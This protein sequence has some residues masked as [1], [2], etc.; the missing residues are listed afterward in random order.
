MWGG[1][2][3]QGGAAFLW[4]DRK[5]NPQEK[6]L[7]LDKETRRV[8]KQIAGER[9]DMIGLL[10]S[11][12]NLRRKAGVH[13]PARPGPARAT[14]LDGGMFFPFAQLEG[15]GSDSGA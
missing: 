2:W 12:A 7:G 4:W 3:G 15:E 6:L 5:N 14:L 9:A 11:H 1:G 13:T 8:K 10:S